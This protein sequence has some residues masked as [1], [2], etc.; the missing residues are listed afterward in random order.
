M[1]YFKIL[2]VHLY[3]SKLARKWYGILTSNGRCDII[4][5]INHVFNAL[6][7]DRVLPNFN[8]SLT[9]LHVRSETILNSLPPI[10]LKEEFNNR[11]F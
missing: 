2:F 8:G 7:T 4:I 6:N 1:K 5:T 9:F 3:H 10:H 11:N